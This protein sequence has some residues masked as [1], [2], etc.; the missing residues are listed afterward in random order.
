MDKPDPTKQPR[1]KMD[2]LIQEAQQ[3]GLFHGRLKHTLMVG[4]EGHQQSKW[5]QH[6][7]TAM[8]VGV[9]IGLA[10]TWM[11]WPVPVVVALFGVCLLVAVT[12]LGIGMFHLVR[13]L[14]LQAQPDEGSE[15]DKD[16]H[17]E[18]KQPGGIECDNATTDERER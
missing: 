14:W 15:A 12:C 10:T 11:G 1:D 13:Y 17:S 5:M 18:A 6:T 3:E 2:R 7:A 9:L 16:A 4:Y 8:I